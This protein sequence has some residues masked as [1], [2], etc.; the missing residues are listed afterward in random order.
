MFRQS[1]NAT[2]AIVSLLLQEALP[3]HRSHFNNFI[4]GIW[5]WAA[6]E[7]CTPRWH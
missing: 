5:A 1:N 4:I 3:I 7:N 2:V 6:I